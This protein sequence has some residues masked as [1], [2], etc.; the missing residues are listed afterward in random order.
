M[1]VL[2][3][4]YSYVLQKGDY[5]NT[6]TAHLFFVIRRISTIY[7]SQAAEYESPDS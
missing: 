3:K 6:R 4:L 7:Q 1:K 5:R 2:F